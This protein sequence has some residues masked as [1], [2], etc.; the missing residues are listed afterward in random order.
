MSVVMLLSIIKPNETA[1]APNTTKKPATVVANKPQAKK[2][3]V[4]N[5]K[6]NKKYYVCVRAYKF[7]NGKKVYGKWSKVKSV[8]TK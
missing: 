1:S 3:T 4:K 7:V 5:L 6:K 8:K 2:K